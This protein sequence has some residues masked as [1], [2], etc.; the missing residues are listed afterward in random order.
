[1]CVTLRS[2]YLS[3]SVECHISGHSQSV[4]DVCA[5]RAIEI[6][7]TRKNKTEYILCKIKYLSE[8]VAPHIA[9]IDMCG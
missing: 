1:M 9:M 8:I 5:R 4:V 7:L 2:A 3:M 6:E